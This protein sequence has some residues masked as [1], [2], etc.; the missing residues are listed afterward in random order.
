VSEAEVGIA[1]VTGSDV[2]KVAYTSAD[3]L[4]PHGTRL[5]AAERPWW[6]RDSY[7]NG[8]NEEIRAWA[9]EQ[10]CRNAQRQPKSGATRSS[11][12]LG[13]HSQQLTL[14]GVVDRLAKRPR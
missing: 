12:L 2:A 3:W 9:E 4:P 10:L 5:P 1:M 6:A 11:A 7:S 14:A 8:R 13:R